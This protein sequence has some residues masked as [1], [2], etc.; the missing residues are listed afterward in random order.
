[1]NRTCADCTKHRCTNICFVA[2]YGCDGYCEFLGVHRQCDKRK[3]K[4]FILDKVF[5]IK[6]N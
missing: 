1:M 3:C 4:Q 6:E 2:K 5:N